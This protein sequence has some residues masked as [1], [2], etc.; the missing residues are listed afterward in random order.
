MHRHHLFCATMLAFASPALAIDAGHDQ[1]DVGQ[2]SAPVETLDEYSSITLTL[3]RVIRE[4]GD[5]G[6]TNLK[7][8][9]STETAQEAITSQLLYY[10]RTSQLADPA[11]RKALDEGEG[12]DVIYVWVKDLDQTQIVVDAGIY[13]RLVAS[14]GTQLGA[15]QA[16]L[17]TAAH[18][19]SISD[20]G[21][22]SFVP[23]DD[24]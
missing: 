2:G 23:A 22:I 9:F 13:E 24:L 18:L 1:V 5:R 6:H 21:F 11:V 16:L 14:K 20:N 10:S 3:D 19:V 7:A 4:G 17:A 15:H 8:V 12:Q